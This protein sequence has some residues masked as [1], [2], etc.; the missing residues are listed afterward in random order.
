MSKIW[1]VAIV[2]SGP[3]GSMAAM[4][5][6]AAGFKTIIIEKDKLPRYKVCGGAIPQEFVES[7]KIPEEIIERKFESLML[8]H[9]KDEILRKGEGACVW[10][11]DL[12]IFMTN[13]ATESSAVLLE[14]T[15]IIK[16]NYKNDLYILHSKNTKIQ[17]K[18]LI[19]ADGVP[20]TILKSFG[21]NSFSKEDIAQTMTY[22]IKLS[23]TKINKR[24]GETCI[25]LYFG[26]NDICDIGYAWLFPKREIIS[27]GWGCQLSN[28]R[29]VREEFQNFLKI[30]NKFIQDG[31][32]IKKA[33]HMCPVGFQ[34]QFNKDGLVLVGDA[35]G[36]VDPLSGKG[37]A[38]AAASGKIAGKVIIKALEEEDKNII[39]KEYEKKLDRD[40]LKALKAKKRIQPDVYKTDKNI[41]RF[42]ELWKNY[43]ST[44]IAQKLWD[45][46]EN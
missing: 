21:W 39:S 12:D 5:L 27:V 30:V 38:Y 18:I 44:I 46:Q 20:S 6:G 13:L 31:K 11:S 32:I 37:I 14:N 7:M 41:R 36:F 25:H 24:L 23:E 28:I 34:K 42:L 2:G 43:R 17:S 33:A 26:K 16:A 40:F 9:L 35:A 1:D 3:A 22:E 15:R 29:N 8:H 4:T 19:A 10:R 45:K